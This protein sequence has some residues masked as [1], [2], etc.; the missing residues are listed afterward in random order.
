M[1]YLW[2][3]QMQKDGNDKEITELECPDGTFKRLHRVFTASEELKPGVVLITL[4]LENGDLADDDPLCV[5]DHHGHW[6]LK[7][8]FSLPKKVWSKVKLQAA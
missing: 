8:F 5:A 6:M 4:R 2:I 3:T 7:E 1:E